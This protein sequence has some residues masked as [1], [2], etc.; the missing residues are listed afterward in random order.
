MKP[1]PI[2]TEH[3]AFD[4]RGPSLIRWLYYSDLLFAGTVWP[5]TPNGIHGAEYGIQSMSAGDPL[6][7]ETVA[8]VDPLSCPRAWVIFH[9]L[10]VIQ[11]VPEEVHSYWHSAAYE[12]GTRSGVW[13]V[14]DSDW[15]AGFN[16]SHLAD[17]K[18]F[19]LEFYDDLV[20]VIARDLI[21]GRGQ[22][23]IDRVVDVDCRFAYAY[24]RRAQVREKAQEWTEAIADYRSYASLE[25]DQSHAAYGLR[26]V[27]ALECKRR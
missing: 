2:S 14:V 23:S 26:C 24:F 6:P 1:L 9:G 10:Q 5:D 17:N 18:H 16:P 4:G 7:S 12:P 20:E 15:L 25:P 27:E 19:I 8:M 3:F 13:E 21:F 11:L 22:F